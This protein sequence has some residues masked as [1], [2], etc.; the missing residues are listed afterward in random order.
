MKACTA[1][2]WGPL[3][4]TLPVYLVFCES[5]SVQSATFPEPDKYRGAT[6]VCSLRLPFASA[7][8]PAH[9][10]GHTLGTHFHCVVVISV[11][12]LD[13]TVGF[14]PLAVTSDGPDP[15][16]MAGIPRCSGFVNCCPNPY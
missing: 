3:S 16:G 13:S 10:H 1:A 4:A 11:A 6:K 9:T 15:I 2:Q 7:H 14:A 5:G 8:L 12:V